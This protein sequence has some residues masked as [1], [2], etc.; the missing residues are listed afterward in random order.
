MNPIPLINGTDGT[1]LTVKPPAPRPRFRRSHVSL[2]KGGMIS[3]PFKTQGN[4][5]RERAGTFPAAVMGWVFAVGRLDTCGR[6]SR[7][8]PNNGPS[9]PTHCYKRL[10]RISFTPSCCASFQTTEAQYRSSLSETSSRKLSGIPKTLS[11]RSLAPASDRSTIRHEIIFP[12]LG[13]ILAGLPSLYRTAFR[14]S[15]IL[16]PSTLELQNGSSAEVV[17]PKLIRVRAGICRDLT[18]SPACVLAVHWQRVLANIEARMRMRGFAAP[19]GWR[20]DLAEQVG[21]KGEGHVGPE[22]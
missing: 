18:L 8:P 14:C 7:T 13:T 2:R 4:E 6:N 20:D 9:A 16:P 10:D 1:R 12:Y 19:A 15:A 22:S 11:T 21:R 5:M 3:T 17:L